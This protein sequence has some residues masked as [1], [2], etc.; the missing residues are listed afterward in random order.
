LLTGRRVSMRSALTEP[1]IA[2]LCWSP[3]VVHLIRPWTEPQPDR[4]G[5]FFAARRVV[6]KEQRSPAMI[7]LPTAVTQESPVR[8]RIGIGIVRRRTGAHSP[9]TRVASRLIQMTQVHRVAPGESFG[10]RADVHDVGG[11]VAG[12]ERKVVAQAA[13]RPGHRRVPG[14]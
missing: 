1:Q 2:A 3:G 12:E 13:D 14:P 4:L 10:T 6:R 7:L 5:R 11:V 8:G 9:D